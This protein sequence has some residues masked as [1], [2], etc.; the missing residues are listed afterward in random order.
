M[1][2]F[3]ALIYNPAGLDPHGSAEIMEA[4]GA[5][6]GRATDA[7]VLAGGEPLAGTDAATTLSVTGGEGGEVATVEGPAPTSTNELAG[8]FVLDCEHF[9]D[10]VKWGS[11]IPSAWLGGHIELRPVV[12]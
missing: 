4:Y 12:N 5:F 8:F 7:G 9:D 11:Q 3:A 1:A 10:A 2:K 6:I